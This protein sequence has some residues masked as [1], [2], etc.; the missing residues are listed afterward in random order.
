MNNL[1][2]IVE[3]RPPGLGGGGALSADLA[4]D[5]SGATNALAKPCA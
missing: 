2:Q 5:G 3:L 1:W 4:L